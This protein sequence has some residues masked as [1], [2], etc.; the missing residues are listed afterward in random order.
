MASEQEHQSQTIN[1]M[2]S[3]L[4]EEPISFSHAFAWTAQTA[5]GLA[6]YIASL[7][8][9]LENEPMYGHEQMDGGNPKCTRITLLRR[10]D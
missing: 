8:K 5:D 1:N 6:L 10:Q 9:P 2:D 7:F 4:Q 3:A